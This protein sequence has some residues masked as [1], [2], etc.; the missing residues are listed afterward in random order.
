MRHLVARHRRDVTHESGCCE[1]TLQKLKGNG[2]LPLRQLSGEDWHGLSAAPWCWTL[3]SGWLVGG[4]LGS[5]PRF[6]LC[7]SPR[8]SRSSRRSP[9]GH[10]RSPLT[11]RGVGRARACAGIL[12]KRPLWL[13]SVSGSKTIFWLHFAISLLFSIP[14]SISHNLQVSGLR[15]GLRWDSPLH[16]GS[17]F[18]WFVALA[19]KLGRLCFDPPVS[20]ASAVLWSFIVSIVL[21]L[22]PALILLSALSPWL[23][24]SLSGA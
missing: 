8:T 4:W 12:G 10:A 22:V 9:W 6:S 3:F 23:F 2:G 5:S 18:R 16:G 15:S 13:R 7:G 11:G 21:G 19:V 17:L 1:N 24:L 20:P 14:F